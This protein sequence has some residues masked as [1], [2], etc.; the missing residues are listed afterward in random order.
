MELFANTWRLFL[1]SLRGFDTSRQ[2]AFGIAL[3]MLIGLVPKTSAIPYA[4]FLITL[5]SNAN[6]LGAG[7]TGLLTSIVSPA[8]DSITHWIGIRVLT[9]DPTEFWLAKLMQ[10]DGTA[11]LQIENTVVTGSVVFGIAL[12]IPVYWI[13]KTV[14]ERFGGMFAEKISRSQF[15]AWLVEPE[16]PV[17]ENF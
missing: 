10:L 16:K 17:T 6:L 15:F 2:I 14:T 1:A 5:L 3:G 11:W 12:F 13:A 4:I 7:V 8:F 9:Y